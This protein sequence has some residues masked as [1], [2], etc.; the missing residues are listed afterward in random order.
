MSGAGRGGGWT[1]E[2]QRR[3]K[4]APEAPRAANQELLSGAGRGGGWTEQ[5]Q[6]RGKPAPEAPR[7]AYGEV[8]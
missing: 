1:E 5:R 2:R 3:G 4:P 7:A 8:R 6:R